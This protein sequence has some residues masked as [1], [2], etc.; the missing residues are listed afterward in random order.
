LILLSLLLIVVTIERE[1]ME[2]EKRERIQQL[3]WEEV[4]TTLL[5]IAV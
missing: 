3:D 4:F 2:R 1:K 5:Y